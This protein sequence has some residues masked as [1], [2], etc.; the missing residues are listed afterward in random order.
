MTVYWAILGALAVAALWA[1]ACGVLWLALAT[2]PP[3]LPPKESEA[4]SHRS[5]A[6]RTGTHS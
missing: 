4:L 2:K 1:M 3:E 5:W 6:R